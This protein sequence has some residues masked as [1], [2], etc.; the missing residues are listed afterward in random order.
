MSDKTGLTAMSG[1][2]EAWPVY[3]SIGNIHK[4]IRWQ[5]SK[6]AMVLLGYLPIPKSLRDEEGEEVHRE[7]AW[8]V[9]HKC[10]SIM[11]QPLVEASTKGMEM[12][13]SDGGV[14]RCYSFLA[15]YVADYPE[16]LQVT[17]TL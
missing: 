15:S 2:K 3:A 9:F 14:W 7:D 11:V 16:Q 10:L 13:C 4:H 6:R 1:G 12:W 5:P 17:C 8:E